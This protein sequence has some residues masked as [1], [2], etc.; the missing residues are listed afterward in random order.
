MTVCTSRWAASI[1]GSPAPCSG[2][3]TRSPR[4][5]R[6][7]VVLNR[8][9][10]GV[11]ELEA[12]F[13]GSVAPGASAEVVGASHAGKACGSAVPD[14][15]PYPHDWG[16]QEDCTALEE[17]PKSLPCSRLP[18]TSPWAQLPQ[19]PQ[20]CASPGREPKRYRRSLSVAMTPR[21]CRQ[22]ARPHEPSS[23]TNCRHSWSS[24]AG[25][26]PSFSRLAAQAGLEPKAR[27]SLQL[28]LVSWSIESSISTSLIFTLRPL[29][30]GFRG[31]GASS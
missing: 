15:P 28:A 6:E 18:C 27:L 10:G 3:G 11:H 21:R 1:H 19:S 14:H 16:G 29:G 30:L 23:A 26:A 20:L 17:A 9:V 13:A 31:F 7:E 25:N 8:V 24:S 2:S 4:G 5:G 22:R 12:A